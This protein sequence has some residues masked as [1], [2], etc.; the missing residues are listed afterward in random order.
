[1]T[2]EVF[3]HLPAVQLKDIEEYHLCDGKLMH[4]PFDFWRQLDG[5][6]ELEW[7]NYEKANPVFYVAR[8]ESENIEINLLLESIE[9]TLH[10][11]SLALLLYPGYYLL[12]D[13]GHSC[14]YVLV[15]G[16]LYFQQV[17]AFN[18]EWIVY[19]DVWYYLYT[20]EDLQQVDAIFKYMQRFEKMYAYPD[21]NDAIYY[22]RE[23]AFV[24]F[25]YE[26]IGHRQSYT[27]YKNGFIRVMSFL[28][29]MLFPAEKNERYELSLTRA[30]GYYG[31]ALLEREPNQLAP[32]AAQLSELYSLRSKLVHGIVLQPDE[33]AQV[34]NQAKLARYYFCRMIIRLMMLYKNEITTE[35]VKVLLSECLQRNGDEVV[36]NLEKIQAYNALMK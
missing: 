33:A 12:P 23:T 17:G 34:E 20:A 2:I 4:L 19:G 32:L 10:D 14:M 36:F 31:A 11:I 35:P 18:R 5:T 26:G 30:F 25:V 7:K 24:D 27:N 6:F 22:L 13:Y 1:M 3:C 28:E 15:D 8:L 16:Q 9:N 21:L 29:S